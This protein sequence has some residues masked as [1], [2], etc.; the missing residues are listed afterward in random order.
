M[1]WPVDRRSL[2][3][4]TRSSGAQQ[5]PPRNP[6]GPGPRDSGIGPCIRRD[7]AQPCDPGRARFRGD[8]RMALSTT[9]WKWVISA[10]LLV[11]L[12]GG[13]PPARAQE[14]TA[15]EV[16]RRQAVLATLPPDAARRVFGL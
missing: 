3:D 7:S 14:N 9:Q 4:V 12:L 1:R 11:M 2:N 6:L 15:E 16:A 8:R 5:S 10:A 13:T